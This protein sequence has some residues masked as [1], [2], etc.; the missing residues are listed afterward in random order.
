MATVNV[1]VYLQRMGKKEYYFKPFTSCDLCT[2]RTDN[3]RQKYLSVNTLL[4]CLDKVTSKIGQS[5]FRP[6]PCSYPRTEMKQV[7]AVNQQWLLF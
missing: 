1:K 5:G 3:E 7:N 2:W 6:A 4:A